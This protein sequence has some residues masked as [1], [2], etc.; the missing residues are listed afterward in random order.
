[1]PFPPASCIRIGNSCTLDF[2]CQTRCTLLRCDAS[3][4]RGCNPDKNIPA[5]HAEVRT[6]DP[7]VSTRYAW[8][9]R[10]PIRLGSCHDC[11]LRAWRCTA[12]TGPHVW[13]CV[14]HVGTFAR[15]VIAV[16]P[17]EKSR[18]TSV[19]V[20]GLLG[21]GVHMH[22]RSISNGKLSCS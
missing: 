13:L 7:P 21:I 4:A 6:I 5:L 16:P 10:I 20:H 14:R 1:M 12:H 11:H 15:H 19:L 3:S 9:Q 17:V 2:T 18:E 8:S 22:D